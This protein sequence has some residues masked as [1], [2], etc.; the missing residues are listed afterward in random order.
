MQTRHYCYVIELYRQYDVI[1][2]IMSNQCLMNDPCGILEKDFKHGI[3]DKSIA[4][5]KFALIKELISKTALIN[6]ISPIERQFLK[7]A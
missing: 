5:N 2:V 6:I 1:K 4:L 7:A 3:A